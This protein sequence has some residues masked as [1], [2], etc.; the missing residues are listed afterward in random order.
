MIG[1]A[2]VVFYAQDQGWV[3]PRQKGI[4]GETTAEIANGRNVPI[5]HKTIIKLR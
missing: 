4:R 1:D 2:V 5:P 3:S